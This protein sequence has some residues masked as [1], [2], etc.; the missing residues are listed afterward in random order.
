EPALP[1]S[2]PAKYSRILAEQVGEFYTQGIAEDTKALSVG[3]LDDKEYLEQSRTVLAEHRRIFDTEIRK[4][5]KGVF[6]FYFSSLDLTSHMMW[7][8]NDRKHPGY[9]PSLAAQNGAAIAEFYEQI[10]QVLGEVLPKIDDYTTLLVLSDHGFA[11]YYRSFNLNTWLLN[12][13]YIKRKSQSDSDSNDPL[14]DVDWEA[15]R[16]Y[17][18]GLNGLYINLRGRERYGTV[19]PGAEADALIQEIK[20]KLL[21]E[22]DPQNGL[23]VITRMDMAREVYRGPYAPSGPDI[24]VG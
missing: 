22:K 19:T 16:A 21:N 23:P 6:F 5:H 18:L 4:F 10:D 15:T 13:G 7:L 3:V 9:D 24:L 14:A 11:P 20:S 8:L 1:L 2:T 17:G 12:N